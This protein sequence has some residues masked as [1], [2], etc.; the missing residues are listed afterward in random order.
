MLRPM[1]DNDLSKSWNAPFSPYQ[2]LP[3]HFRLKYIYILYVYMT[4][5]KSF[6]IMFKIFKSLFYKE[7]HFILA[8]GLHLHEKQKNI[9]AS[10]SFANARIQ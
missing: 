4:N 5:I 8:F 9:S 1:G 10:C 3:S 6:K 2:T 7:I